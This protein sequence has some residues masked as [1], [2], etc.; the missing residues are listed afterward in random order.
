MEEFIIMEFVDTPMV[1]QPPI[2]THSNPHSAIPPNPR[3]QSANYEVARPPCPQ[4]IQETVSKRV[5]S[6]QP[7]F[8]AVRVDDVMER[9]GSLTH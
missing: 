3:P 5:L 7:H 8:K 1:P 9:S 6:S 4:G 2:D